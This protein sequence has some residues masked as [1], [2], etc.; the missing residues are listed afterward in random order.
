MPC[1]NGDLLDLLLEYIL[2]VQYVTDEA[3][4]APDAT[5]GFTHINT[6]KRL[7]DNRQTITKQLDNG[8]Q[9]SWCKT[10]FLRGTHHDLESYVSAQHHSGCT[11]AGYFKRQ[12][13]MA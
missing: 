11:N 12:L 13:K 10:A 2:I 5:S 8:Y 4:S 1:E 6:Q 7:A 9:D 3:Y